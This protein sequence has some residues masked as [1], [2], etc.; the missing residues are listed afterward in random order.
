MNTKY[1]PTR[2]SKRKCVSLVGLIVILYFLDNQA[3]ASLLGSQ[4]FYSVLKPLF[5]IGLALVVW[6]FPRV[7]TKGKLR[8]KEFLN[9]WAFN[10]AVIYLAV[11]VLAG[12]VDGFGK[13]PYDQSLSGMALNLVLIGSVLVGKEFVRS[14][15][16]NSFTD[17]DKYLKLIITALFMTFITFSLS[18]YSGLK[19]YEDSVQFMAQYFLPEFSINLFAT[20]L[21]YLGGP[22]P[23]IIYIGIL[24][25]FHW[26]SP[27]LPN[28]QWITTALVGI[29]CPLFS[30]MIVQSVYL[31]EA[32][33]VKRRDKGEEGPIGWIVTSLI[34][35]AIIW[36]AAGVFSVY[37]SVIV[38]GSM[39]PMIKPGD[40][41]L[42]KKVEDINDI[43]MG[44]VVQFKR[45]NI[46]ISHRIIEIVEDGGPKS[47][48]TKGD[49]NSVADSNLVKPEQIKGQ[50]IQ[51]VPKIGWPTLLL[52]SNSDVPLDEIE[53]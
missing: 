39:E 18:K 11:L 36:F 53:F 12:L 4:F 3:V 16:I 25:A 38:T 29:M 23:A 46:L 7:R 35:I 52:K 27:I 47:Y 14:Y 44:D 32:R 20:Y 10:F 17:N 28:L 22:V 42:V 51:V 41:I 5:W 13:S 31:I 2:P 8:H 19:G 9:W 6:L 33:M 40:V 24:Q 34:S 45:G 15:L 50:I 49:N 30:L 21:A 26:F 1:L 48:R 37:P 43:K